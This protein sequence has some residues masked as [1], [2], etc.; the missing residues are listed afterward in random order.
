MHK[1]LCGTPSTF[2]HLLWEQRV[3]MGKSYIPPVKPILGKYGDA[4]VFKRF[5]SQPVQGY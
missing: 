4:P 3:S 2:K 5:I 1:E